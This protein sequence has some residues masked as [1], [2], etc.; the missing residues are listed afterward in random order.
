MRS[1]EV[2]YEVL[3]A[4]DPQGRL[5]NEDLAPAKE[6][7]RTW[8]T[9]SLFSLWMNDAHNASNYMFAAGLY[10]GTGTL[11][12]MTPLAIVVGILIATF[13]IFVACNITGYMGY[14]TGAPY[15]VVS[16]VTWGVMGANFPAIVRGIVAIGWYGIQTYVA[17]IALDLIIIRFI[18]AYGNMGANILGLSAHGWLS[19][20]ILSALQLAVVWRGMDSVN[21]FQ[22]VAGPIIWVIMLGLGAWMLSQANWHFDWTHNID[23]IA[24]G[25]GEQA[26]QIL[27]TI[28]LT[29]GTL[30]TLMLNFSD[31]A[32]FAP[33]KRSVVVG[34]VLG[35]PLNWTAFAL[36]AVVCSAAAF[37]VYGEAIHDPGDLIKH[38][39]NDPLFLVVSLGFV[40]AT[41]GVNIVANF[42][43]SAFDLSNVAPKHLSFQ[44][45]G[46]I[47]VIVSVVVTPWN[48]YNSPTAINLF[49]GG[50]GALLGP[51]FGILVLDYFYYKKSNIDLK[52]LY[53][54]QP[55]GRYWYVGGLNMN[56]LF[57]LI[58]AAAV[59]LCIALIPW[60]VFQT[61][62][63]F[64]W[65]IAA[66]LGALC[67]W[68]VVSTR[69]DMATKTPVTANEG[70]E[71]VK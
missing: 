61:I 22:G 36:T 39:N 17:S 52:E 35:L 18:P 55:G 12:G 71:N 8:G 56:A 9:Y 51:F 38:I 4:G 27:V 14:E 41:I 5:L 25:G 58:P 30:A 67:Y 37:N 29:I 47:A 32:R 68:I 62:A 28:G 1:K 45:A 3:K 26:Y 10:I 44:K 34:N 13:V 33:S 15:P 19:F 66:P 57:A 59:S 49:L 6:E 31:F 7:Q 65:F 2:P 64:S 63:P 46:I 20:L 11:M 69:G 53:S 60:H 43:S 70:M 50:L 16:R 24:P 48:L 23:G 21:H 54:M 42:V 40:V